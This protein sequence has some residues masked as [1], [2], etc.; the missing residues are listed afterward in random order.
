MA[1]LDY[2]IVCCGLIPGYTAETCSIFQ[3]TTSVLFT[4][5][6]QGFCDQL[7]RCFKGQ[8]GTSE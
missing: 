7:S 1:Y 8:L 6:A 3:Q 5:K 4:F 2:E